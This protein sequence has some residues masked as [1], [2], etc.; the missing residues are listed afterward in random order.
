MGFEGVPQEET[1]IG[2]TLKTER[3]VYEPETGFETR[4]GQKEWQTL[5]EKKDA[6]EKLTGLN[7]EREEEYKQLEEAKNDPERSRSE[8]LE[9]YKNNIGKIN[10]QIND[11]MLLPKDAP[12]ATLHI[13]ENYIKMLEEE[14]QEVE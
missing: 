6:L 9:H 8:I 11:I 14:I 3:G 10:S 5:E 1:N 13:F 4:W 7:K 12:S 2:D